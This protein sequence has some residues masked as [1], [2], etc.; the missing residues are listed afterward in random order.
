MTRAIRVSATG[1]PDVLRYETI[2]LA[3]PG[4]GQVRLAHTAIGINYIDVYHRIGLYP[5]PFRRSFPVSKASV[6]WKR[7]DQV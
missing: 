1:G 2:E 3:P 6:W 7:Q 4:P 5:Q